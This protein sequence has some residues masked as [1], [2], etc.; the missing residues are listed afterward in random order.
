M[1]LL[2]IKRVEDAEFETSNRIILNLDLGLGPDDSNGMEMSRVV[3]TI[4][5]NYYVGSLTR[6][7]IRHQ[8]RLIC[9]NILTGTVLLLYGHFP[10][11]SRAVFLRHWSVWQHLRLSAREI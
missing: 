2:G 5:S 3:H 9:I 7:P 4:P 10:L 1:N 6:S 11:P 8:V